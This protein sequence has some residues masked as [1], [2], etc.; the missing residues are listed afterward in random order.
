VL[1]VFRRGAAA[2]RPCESGT[3]CRSR[4]HRGRRP[5]IQI[6]RHQTR[7]PNPRHPRGEILAT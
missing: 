5:F 6:R 2:L 3:A 1:V 4:F 7:K